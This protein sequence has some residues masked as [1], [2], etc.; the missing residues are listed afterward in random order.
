[1]GIR[2]P[3]AG[4]EA[5][6]GDAEAAAGAEDG[7]PEASARAAASAAD[8]VGGNSS[9]PPACM[10]GMSCA[11]QSSEVSGVEHV[12]VGSNPL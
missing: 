12:E 3:A 8:M 2:V 7:D 1:M 6:A 10:P 9:E 5:A 11:C 4:G